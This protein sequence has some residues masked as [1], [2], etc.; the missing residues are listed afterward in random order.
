MVA[1]TYLN[2]CCPHINAGYN[3]L[4]TVDDVVTEDTLVW[5][6]DGECYDFSVKHAWN[7][8]RDRGEEVNCAYLVWS[9]YTIPRHTTRLWLVM[10]RRL[11]TQDR[12]RQWHV[13]NEVDLALLRCPLCKVNSAGGRN[14]ISLLNS[15]ICLWWVM[16][17]CLHHYMYNKEDKN[18]VTPILL[19]GKFS[20][21]LFHYNCFTD[22]C[23][24]S[25]HLGRANQ[26]RIPLRK[27]I[28]IFDKSKY[29]P[30]SSGFD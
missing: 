26:S 17:D 16:N 23:L 10:R 2:I 11:L 12:M 5:K 14:G 3:T 30:T 18:D 24:D 22:E 1:Y 28:N 15:L 9:K 25:I 8:T 21:E 27:N 29:R 4:E 19:H 13:G 20:R 6:Y 7:A